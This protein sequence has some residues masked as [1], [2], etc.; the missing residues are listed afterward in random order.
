[1]ENGCAGQVCFVET[2]KLSKLRARP[3]RPAP[4]PTFPAA[5]PESED[6]WMEGGWW[7]VASGQRLL[8]IC[9]RKG[10]A[11]DPLA[12]GAGQPLTTNH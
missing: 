3:G 7:L 5:M 1:M 6:A 2:V 9:R 11:G 12:P 8:L 10:G 4:S